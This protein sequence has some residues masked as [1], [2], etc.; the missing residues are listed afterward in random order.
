LYLNYALR[1]KHS[2][3][4][5]CIKLHFLA[6]GLKCFLVI[7]AKFIGRCQLGV[8]ELVLPVGI[9]EPAARVIAERLSPQVI[10]ERLHAVSLYDIGEPRVTVD[11]ELSLPF[12]L[13]APGM[14]HYFLSLVIPDDGF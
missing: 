10:Q 14:L 9:V 12:V 13:S 1:G 6:Q 7:R 8:L 11:Q 4:A 3:S 5:A 2:S